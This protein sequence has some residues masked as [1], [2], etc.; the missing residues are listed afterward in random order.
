MR[1]VILIIVVVLIILLLAACGNNGSFSAKEQS[2][3]PNTEMENV[4]SYRL[5]QAS[6][7]YGNPDAFKGKEYSSLFMIISEKQQYEDKDIYYANGY[8][9]ESSIEAYT[10]LSFENGTSPDL[11]PDDII[12]ASGIIDGKASLFD[13][14][15]NSVDMLWISVGSVEIDAG[16]ANISTNNK[17]FMFEEGKYI[18]QNNTLAIEVTS[19]EFSQDNTIL[20]TKTGD[21]SVKIRTTYYFDIIIHQDGYFAWYH[22]CNFWIEP[23][24]EVGYDTIP[25]PIMDSAK[26]LAIEFVPYSQNGKLIYE[27]LTLDIELSKES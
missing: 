15:G 18:A 17:K 8:I 12:Y 2:Y 22:D 27:P 23:N 21:D 11:A 10:V 4:S 3:E 16:D 25:F 14:A 9:N 24:G 5:S 19:L 7:I 26:D 1:K 20:F 6:E 13:D